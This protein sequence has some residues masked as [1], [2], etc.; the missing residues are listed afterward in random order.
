MT[1]VTQPM[2]DNANA[3][4]Y[5]MEAGV[6]IWTF[7][8][9]ALY[10]EQKEK[11][12]HVSWRPHPAPLLSKQRRK[13]ITNN[14][15]EFSKKYNA[16]DDEARDRVREAFKKERDAKTDLFNLVLD[17]ISQYKEEK[18]EGGAAGWRTAWDDFYADLEWGEED[19]IIEDTLEV[20]E[21]LIPNA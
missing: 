13:Y 8:G 12:W 1:A 19:Q 16:L 6:S 3:F 20:I 7:Q 21:E 2:N 17:R 10:R 18:L 4:K 9:R 15:K 11:L 5:Q 14:I